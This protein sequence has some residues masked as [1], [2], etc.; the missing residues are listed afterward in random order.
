ML[1]KVQIGNIIS[2]PPYCL[3]LQTIFVLLLD[4]LI[5]TIK[6]CLFC[7]LWKFLTMQCS[8]SSGS[9]ERQLFSADRY[10]L[11]KG[12]GALAW[13]HFLTANK[14]MLRPVEFQPVFAIFQWPALAKVAHLKHSTVIP[15][16]N[17]CSSCTSWSWSDVM[18]SNCILGH[19]KW[20]LSP[21][22]PMQKSTQ[23]DSHFA[24]TL[25]LKGSFTI[26]LFSVRTHILDSNEVWYSWFWSEGPKN[27][28]N[29]KFLDFYFVPRDLESPP[30]E[31]P[32]GAATRGPWGQN[33]NP[34]NWDLG[35][36]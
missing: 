12:S 28:L 16:L 34:K 8:H 6:K 1:S 32:C 24:L 25:L 4:E 11:D 3:S 14:Q 31:V 30:Y 20:P 26:F 36:F 10:F 2:P 5:K 21:D 35:R 18:L 22:F 33:K 27:A 29:P 7:W 13:R 17:H 19:N 23:K 9:N 15:E